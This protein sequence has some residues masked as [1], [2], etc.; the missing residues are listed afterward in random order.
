LKK[1]LVSVIIN[2]FNGEE[3]LS[4]CIDSILCSS[5]HN[6]E[7]IFFD[8]ASTDNSLKVVNAY[9]DS[10]IKKCIR[11]SNVPLGLARKEAL[12]LTNGELIC[13]LDV[14]DIL[15]S[16]AFKNYIDV[17]EE[18]SFDVFYGGIY[19]IN[20]TSE[21]IGSYKP[22]RN[23]NVLADDLLKNFDVNVPSLCI[24]KK[25]L[26]TKGVEFDP[27]IKCCEE[28]DIMIHM[29]SKNALIISSPEIFSSYRIH[30]NSLTA[31][32]LDV[33]AFE[34][35]YILDKYK[36]T[37]AILGSKYYKHAYLKS[38]YY[39]ARYYFDSGNLDMARANMKKTRS[40]SLIFKLLYALLIISPT[41]W[42]KFHVLKGR[43]VIR[44]YG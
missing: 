11:K 9:S 31:K 3:Y 7:I 26:I 10:R 16:N 19:R 22:L 12:K 29:I 43:R 15:D 38:Y 17:W 8:N 25:A 4:D 2:C 13:F 44:I 24:S 5:Y 18:T 36:K 30:E 20:A 40:G 39:E 21:T 35:R 32:N 6:F 41:L 23:T 28:F 1:A 14:D 37:S 27:S 42:S 34:R 33:A